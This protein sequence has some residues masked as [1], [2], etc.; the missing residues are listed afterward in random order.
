MNKQIK[1]KT[2]DIEKFLKESNAI[3]QEFSVIALKDALKAWDYLKTKSFLT[4]EVILGVHHLLA[5]HIDPDIAGQWRNCDVWIGGHKKTFVSVQ[6]IEE[7]IASAI[8]SMEMNDK[9]PTD[10]LEEF[11]KQSHIEFE[12]IHPFQDGN[13]RTGRL[14]YLWHRMKLGLPIH[15]IHADWDK[16]GNEQKNYYSWFKK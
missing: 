14:I 7:D 6:L 3:E 11:T 8:S 13:G 2:E 9:L 1:Y 16:G 12:E 4:L 10:D 5:R 15:I